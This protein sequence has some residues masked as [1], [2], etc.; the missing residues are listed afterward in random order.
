MDLIS[1]NEVGVDLLTLGGFLFS[2]IEFMKIVIGLRVR[3]V[4]FV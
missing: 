4:G 3:A 1:C 2:L